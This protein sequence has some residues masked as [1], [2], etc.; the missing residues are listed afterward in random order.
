MTENR[1]YKVLAVDDDDA[2]LE[3]L[4][5]VVPRYAKDLGTVI[6]ETCSSFDEAEGRLK[7]FGADYDLVILDVMDS[8]PFGGGSEDGSRGATL[9]QRI[10]NVRWV[11]VIFYT[12]IP[13]NVDIPVEPPLLVVVSKE[14]TNLLRTSITQSLSSNAAP[15]ARALVENLDSSV[16]SFLSQHVSPHWSAYSEHEESDLQ[17]VLVNRLSAWLREWKT[18]A[19]ETI[20]SPMDG[21]VPSSAYYLLPPVTDAG[22]R[23]GSILRDPSS[24]ELWI[25]MTPSC[26]LYIGGNRSIKVDR[27]LLARL[28]RAEEQPV[29]A[30]YLE[31]P[32]PSK[33][34]TKEA[35][36][37]LKSQHHQ[38]RWYFLPSFLII[39]DLFVDLEDIQSVEQEVVSQWDRLADL[40]TPFIESLLARQSHWRGRIGTPDFGVDAHLSR[41]RATRWPES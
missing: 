6:V 10:R 19:G 3:R 14:N 37:L 36:S 11:P 29:V 38:P 21:T 17:L 20:A 25:V 40:D 34:A 32:A 7:A 22:L 41:M 27:I 2:V 23:A 15:I 1:Q 24:E 28:T 13:E 35:V 9:Y 33:T 18:T 26:D 4:Q 31:D 39:P 5:Y 8:H 12:A 16:R 30:K